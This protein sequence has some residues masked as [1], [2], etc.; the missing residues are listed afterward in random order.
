[1]TPSPPPDNDFEA[2]LKPELQRL[3]RLAFRLLGRAADAE[4]LVQDVL[5]KVYERRT[6]LTSIAPLSPW[7]A[8]VLY[9]HFIDHTRR[10]TKE[11]LRTVPLSAMAPDEP[12]DAHLASQQPGP[13]Q[14]A[15]QALDKRLL[16]AALAE[17][18]LDHRAVLL[19]H[20]SEGYKLHEIQ[21]ITGVSLGTLKSRLHRARS[22]LREI[23]ARHGT[24]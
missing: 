19:M 21:I 14:N 2:L 10:Y 18:S 9:N 12:D 24:F 15:S 22:R 5:I 11:R 4:D 17:L 20:D 3:Y 1:V 16:T 23:L 13:E 8:R 7:L 6:E